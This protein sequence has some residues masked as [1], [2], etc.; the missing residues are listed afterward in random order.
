MKGKI[1]AFDPKDSIGRIEQADGVFI[2]FGATACDFVPA[3]GIEV[4]VL[5][6]SPSPLGG[7]KATRVRALGDRA[8]ANAIID[9][10]T[11]WAPTREVESILAMMI[12]YG[13]ITFVVDH[14]LEGPAALRRLFED[15][16][17]GVL[18]FEPAPVLTLG[19]NRFRLEVADAPIETRYLDSAIPG[20]P[21]TFGRAFVSLVPSAFVFR[22]KARFMV[23]RPDSQFDAW[24]A[25][26][27]GLVH[28]ALDALMP[29]L[30]GYVMHRANNALL[31]SPAWQSLVSSSTL[32]ERRT[33]LP[34]VRSMAAGDGSSLRTF[35][36]EVWA[37][38]DVWLRTPDAPSQAA[39]LPV[40][41]N[42]CHEMSV[43]GQ[44]PP[45]GAF[46]QYPSLD[47][48]QVE[49][50]NDAFVVASPYDASRK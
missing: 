39:A 12:E 24:T 50:S 29:K 16:R 42:L 8:A 4:D 28:G 14:P 45:A 30:C 38:P 10:Q 22:D 15:P 13:F 37:L 23:W 48:W 1:V 21:A 36:M 32:P 5:S 31:P 19:E 17:T 18:S 2:R 3:L 9:Q 25:W 11:G 33:V 27:L 41:M 26:G 46:L 40:A 49:E 6:T 20:A 35:G 47:T 34:W 7:L 43:Y 44:S